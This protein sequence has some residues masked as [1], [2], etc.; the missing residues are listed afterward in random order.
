M[1]D[2][3]MGSQERKEGKPL[4]HK[5]D[6]RIREKEDE[7]NYE[8]ERQGG[9]RD[10]RDLEMGLLNLQKEGNRQKAEARGMKG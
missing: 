2:R 8:E 6:K 10:K 1:R 3:E 7:E 4:R 5:E 9:Q